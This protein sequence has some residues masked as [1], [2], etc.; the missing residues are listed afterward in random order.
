VKIIQLLEENTGVIIHDNG[1]GGISLNIIP[2]A[3]VKKRK[4]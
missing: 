1:L 2:K 3:K 4:Q